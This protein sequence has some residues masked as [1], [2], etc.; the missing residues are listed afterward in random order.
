MTQMSTL[1]PL[2]KSLNIPEQIASVT[3][4]TPSSLCIEETAEVK[5]LKNELAF[6]TV[7]TKNKQDPYSQAFFVL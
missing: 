4:C 3:S 6:P 2:P 5:I 1:E 7:T